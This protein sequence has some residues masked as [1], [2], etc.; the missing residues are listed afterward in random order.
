M[1]IIKIPKCE[2]KLFQEIRKEILRKVPFALINSE[3]LEHDKTGFF[4]F[5]DS[6]YIPPKLERYRIQPPAEPKFDFSNIEFQEDT[7]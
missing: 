1:R 6:D 3:Y 7:E 4:Y 2:P 5:W